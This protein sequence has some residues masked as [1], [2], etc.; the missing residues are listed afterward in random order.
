[1]QSAIFEVATIIFAAFFRRLPTNLEG[2]HALQLAIFGVV[3]IKESQGNSF[4]RPAWA[5][6]GRNQ[7][8]GRYFRQEVLAELQREVLPC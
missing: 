8:S 3:Q 5:A 7:R 2:C 6:S 4:R 1:M